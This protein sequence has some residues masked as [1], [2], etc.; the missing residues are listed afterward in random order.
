MCNT[1]VEKKAKT[2]SEAPVMEAKKV[3]ETTTAAEADAGLSMNINA[4][5][6]KAWEDKTFAEIAAAPPSALQGMAERV[7]DKFAQLH[8]HTVKE[9]GEWPFFLWARAIVTLAAKEISNKRESASKMNI[10]QALDKE[11]EGKSLT[12]ILQLPPKALQGIGPKY[13][14]LLD[15][16]GGIKT[17]EA[18]G[19]WKFAQWANA[20][21]ECAKVENADMSHR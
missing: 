5:V 16:I 14:S 8:I 17:I 7:D 18:L 10:N 9:L 21:A 1:H 6:D 3:E 13:E 4:A 19:T 11:Y 15:E 2:D 12:E 20:I